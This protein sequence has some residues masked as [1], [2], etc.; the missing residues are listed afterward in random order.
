MLTLHE[1]MLTLHDFH[2]L[3]FF[4]NR[5]RDAVISH[6]CS[7]FIRERLYEMSDPYQI[8]VCS[9]CGMFATN[10]E[11]CRICKDSLV[12]LAVPYASKL[13][14]QELMAMGIKVVFKVKQ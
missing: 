7:A 12:R 13:L 2:F 5:E 6:G 9:K 3:F 10:L 4:D 1:Y 14:I 11:D 8:V